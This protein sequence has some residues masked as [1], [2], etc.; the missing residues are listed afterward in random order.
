M[1]IFAHVACICAFQKAIWRLPSDQVGGVWAPI[2]YH[3]SGT[4]GNSLDYFFAPVGHRFHVLV[5]CQAAGASR[6]RHCLS[7]FLLH[8]ANYGSRRRMVRLHAVYHRWLFLQPC[9]SALHEVVQRL[10]SGSGS[11]V[12]E[13]GIILHPP[14][15]DFLS[16]LSPRYFWN[17]AAI[18]SVIRDFVSISLTQT[19][20]RNIGSSPSYRSVVV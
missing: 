4:R 6:S 1:N 19:A 2:V 20:H 8:R 18:S 9:A 16:A 5:S 12:S 13:F 11:Q 17:N 10:C 15:T 3:V 14:W 7:S